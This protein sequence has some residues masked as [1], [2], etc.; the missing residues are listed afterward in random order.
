MIIK[1]KIFFNTII[2]SKFLSSSSLPL[3]SQSD[4]SFHFCYDT[5]SLFPYWTIIFIED[6]NTK[7]MTRSIIVIS[8][9]SQLLRLHCSK[10][11]QMADY[12]GSLK[13][14]GH[15]VQLFVNNQ[16]SDKRPSLCIWIPTDTNNTTQHM[17]RLSCR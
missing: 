11:K 9:S 16:Q 5:I 7:Y 17:K 6:W 13:D 2:H 4:S 12:S 14:V 1:L 10:L 3:V 8:E 15:L